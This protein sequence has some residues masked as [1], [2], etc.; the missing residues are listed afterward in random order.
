MLLPLDEPLDLPVEIWFPTLADLLVVQGRLV[1]RT[2][3][4]V[5][6]ELDGPVQGVERGTKVILDAGRERGLRIR[7]H[8][9]EWLE[10]RLVVAF[11][12]EAR[13]DERASRRTVAS[14]K[15]RWHVCPTAECIQAWI[16]RGMAPSPPELW[17]EASETVEFSMTGLRFLG[18]EGL[19]PGDRLLLE[20]EV[21]GS[22]T[23]WPAAA[24]VRRV[25]EDGVAAEFSELPD[26]LADALMLYALELDGG[27]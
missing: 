19:S 25:S 22:E 20:V 1:L 23:A 7:G 5:V 8:A 26:G 16:Q 17:D 18:S 4:A 3:N 9:M 12:A 15:I 27:E 21:P 24:V 2:A 10:N 14:L 13:S 6:I 11:E